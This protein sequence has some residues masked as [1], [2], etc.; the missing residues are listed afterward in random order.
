MFLGKP[1]NKSEQ[2][3]AWEERPLSAAQIEYAALDAAVLPA[4]LAKLLKSTGMKYS[5]EAHC[6]SLEKF[7]DER[8]FYD[9]LSIISLDNINISANV[10]SS[11]IANEIIAPLIFNSSNLVSDKSHNKPS[12]I[13][14]FF[15]FGII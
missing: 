13:W 6:F 8:D 5:I 9:A 12:I 10:R 11:F 4:I 14:K 15:N 7:H 3:S 1:L 2:C